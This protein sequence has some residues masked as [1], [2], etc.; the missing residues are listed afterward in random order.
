MSYKNST[1]Q[2]IRAIADK[3]KDNVSEVLAK[4]I[5]VACTLDLANNLPDDADAAMKQNIQDL[6]TITGVS[7]DKLKKGDPSYLLILAQH[8]PDVAK[9]IEPTLKAALQ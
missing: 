2:D 8:N 4:Q 1:Y 5:I 9:L 3:L 6:L 7:P